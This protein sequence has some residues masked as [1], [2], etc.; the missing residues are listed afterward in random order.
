MPGVA[1]KLTLLAAGAAALALAVAGCGGGGGGGPKGPPLT[2]DA[3]QA[4][5]Q[6]IAKQIGSKLGSAV[7]GAT[8]SSKNDLAGAQK[9]I[10]AFA[11]ELAKVNPPGEVKSAHDGFVQGM[12]EFADDLG[13]LDEKLKNIKDPGE[14]F[15]A[16]FGLKSF[17]TLLKAQAEFKAKGYDLN[18]NG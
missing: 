10:R 17:Q 11:N 15:G 7:G 1:R 4:K 5:I 18:L 6:E 8:G 13:G 3:Y 16:L 2:K 9:A 14:A 12:R